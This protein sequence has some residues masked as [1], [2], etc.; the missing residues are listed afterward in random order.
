MSTLKKKKAKTNK[1][2][3]ENKK[4]KAAGLKPIATKKIVLTREQSAKAKET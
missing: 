4:L 3:N 2:R 1:A